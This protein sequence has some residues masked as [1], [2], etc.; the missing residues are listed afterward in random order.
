M[1]GRCVGTPAE[2]ARRRGAARGAARAERSTWPLRRRRYLWPGCGARP[3]LS[4]TRPLRGRAQSPA[5]APLPPAPPRRLQ[6]R[7]GKEGSICREVSRCMEQGAG[8]MQER[9]SS[10]AA[11][12]APGAASQLVPAQRSRLR[13]RLVWQRAEKS[14]VSR[15]DS[16]PKWMSTCGSK[17]EKKRNGRGLPVK[18]HHTP[19]AGAP[20]RCE[21]QLGSADPRQ[22]G[23]GAQG[24]RQQ[25]SGSHYTTGG[26]ACPTI[27][28]APTT[29]HAR[30]PG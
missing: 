9:A 7:R 11:L 25:G 8:S 13:L 6:Q 2:A 12:R 4:C 22:A 26:V 14:S 5:V 15:T 30:A 23:P 21:Q 16:S 3:A 18:P 10:R 28:H 29:T 19:A 24:C 20:G 1:A 27:R 17:N